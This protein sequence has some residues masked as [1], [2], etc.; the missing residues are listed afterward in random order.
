[1]DK[2]HD[3]SK[4]TV[5]E[6]PLLEDIKEFKARM[7]DWSSQF[8]IRLFLDSNQYNMPHQEY[9]VLLAV[10]C[11]Y[12]PVLSSSDSLTELKT[13]HDACPDWFFGH[14][15]YD[16]RLQLH[17]GLTGKPPYSVLFPVAYFF[18]PEH[19]LYLR[20]G[21]DMLTIE[22]FGSPD[23]LW[24]RLS[25]STVAVKPLPKLS[26]TSALSRE[27][28]LNTVADLREHIRNGDCYEI[29]LCNYNF[30]ERVELHA[31]SAFNALNT[32]SPAP[33]SAFYQFGNDYLMSASPE[34]YMKKKA[35]RVI[36][37]PIKGTAPR[38]ATPDMDEA[39][40]QALLTD[41]KERAENIMIV[42]L[43][44]NDLALSCEVGSV[45]VDELFGIY[46][47]PQVH[48]MIST[49][50][51]SLRP[52]QHWSDAI[53]HSFPMG[54]MTGAPKRKVMQLIDTYEPVGRGLF[55]GA[56]GYVSPNGDFDFNVVIRSL[57]YGKQTQVLSYYTGGAITYDSIAEQEWEETLLKGR[58]MQQ[59]FR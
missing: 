38:S 39:I 29:N 59:I 34:R 8:S 57:F 25:S 30:A 14:F 3:S 40:K 49:V 1:M 13:Q 51:G 56:V 28:Y 9:E 44:R 55:S 53:R 5:A 19:V 7:L 46:S 41:P 54:S 6:F 21:S 36:S 31:E 4:R 26:F 17:T 32:L 35:N 10:G 58:A 12:A 47:F 48:Q 20:H 37:Q 11:R 23:L 24:S 15:S 22:T 52:D 42:D 33:F 18:V 45:G 50:S 43:V 27:Q 2:N 16:L